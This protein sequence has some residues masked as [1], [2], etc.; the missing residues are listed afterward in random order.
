MTVRLLGLLSLLFVGSTASAIP[1]SLFSDID[2]HLKRSEQILVV[3]C[4]SVPEE[5]QA[6]VDGL[7]PAEVEVLRTVKGDKRPAAL[8]VATVHAMT[9]GKRYLISSSGGSAFETDILAIGELTVVPVPE[10][11]KLSLLDGKTAKQQVQLIFA[12]HLY[13]IERQLAP[14]LEAQRSLTLAVEGRDDHVY[15]SQKNIALGEIRELET[16]NRNSTRTL[17]LGGVPLVWSHAAP[18]ESGYFY[19]SDHLEATPDWEFAA[20]DASELSELDGN[21]LRAVFYGQYSPGRDPKLG[22]PHGN[23]ISVRVG[24]ILL[25]RTTNQPGTIYLLKLHQQGESETLRVRYAVW[26]E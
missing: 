15:Q 1:Y 24:Q 2:T 3:K 17:E 9:P 10:N 19:F 8:R 18:G 4:V 6:F 25:A 13:E 7:Y 22:Q 5:P 14:L 16:V 11:F 23:A 21:P 20:S 26:K 12:R